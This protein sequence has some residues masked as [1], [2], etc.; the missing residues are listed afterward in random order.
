MARQGA[1]ATAVTSPAPSRPYT[2]I[3]S[4][5]LPEYMWLEEVNTGADSACMGPN[6]CSTTFPGPEVCARREP[7]LCRVRACAP[8]D[9]APAVACLV[10]HVGRASAPLSTARCGSR[11]AT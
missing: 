1:P 10:A 9:A 3:D 4:V 8:A 6:K 2:Q 7:A 5:G 11:R